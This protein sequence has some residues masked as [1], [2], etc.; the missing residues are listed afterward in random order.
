LLVLREVR[1]TLDLLLEFS[2]TIVLLIDP[3]LNSCGT[4]RPHGAAG[5]AHTEPGFYI[6]GDEELRA[7]RHLLAGGGEW[8]LAAMLTRL[9]QV[10][11]TAVLAMLVLHFGFRGEQSRRSRS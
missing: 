7:G 8:C 11:I 9:G 4:V 2:D 3:D 5:R 1:L 10:S 6:A